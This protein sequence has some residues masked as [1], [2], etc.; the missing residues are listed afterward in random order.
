MIEAFSRELAVV[1]EDGPC[2]C[3]DSLVTCL[4]YVMMI[5][6][7]PSVLFKFELVVGCVL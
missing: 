1:V 6:P 5:S 4:R 2:Q 7:L 3:I